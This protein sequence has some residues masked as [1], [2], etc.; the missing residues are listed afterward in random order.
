MLESQP[1]HRELPEE[2]A[3]LLKNAAWFMRT[4]GEY[5]EAEDLVVNAIKSRPT[6]SR[7]NDPYTLNSMSTLALILQY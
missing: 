6:N 7:E 5:K 4:K 2:W 3:G 1:A